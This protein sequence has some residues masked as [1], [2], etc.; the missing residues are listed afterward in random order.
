MSFST[1]LDG[2]YNSNLE[3]I[4]TTSNVSSDNVSCDNLSATNAGIA[5]LTTTIFAPT[6]I[7]AGS[8]TTTNLSA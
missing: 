6:N 7:N 2:N 3:F 8:I 4:N 5:L 1:R